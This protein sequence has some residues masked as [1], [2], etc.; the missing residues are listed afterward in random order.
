MRRLPLLLSLALGLG[1]CVAW[2]QSDETERRVAR[3][4][5]NEGIDLYDKGEYE[6]AL[7]RLSRAYAVLKAPTLGLWLA[8]ALAKNGKLVQASERYLEVVR[9]QLEPDAPAQF[10]E[11]QVTA[12]KENQ[13][14]Q[15]RIP[16]VVLAVENAEA[17]A[18]TLTVDGKA[19]KSAMIG[20]PLP[21][22]PG[23]RRVEGKL[24]EQ[25]VAQTGWVSVTFDLAAPA[26]ADDGFDPSAVIDFGVNFWTDTSGGNLAYETAGSSHGTTSRN[27]RKQ[28]LSLMRPPPKRRC[29]GPD[30]WRDGDPVM[31]RGILTTLSIMPSPWD[32]CITFMVSSWQVRGR[33]QC[34]RPCQDR[35]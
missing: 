31:P 18:V 26:Y 9:A 14:L 35:E 1:A 17:S 6:T 24:G 16:T 12:E 11:A 28:R 13:E 2:G 15:A 27:S 5:G 33:A 20:I 32:C 4:L 7:D 8:R 25:A 34:Y 10:R 19:V 29:D 3:T 22:N 21:L 30:T 23:A